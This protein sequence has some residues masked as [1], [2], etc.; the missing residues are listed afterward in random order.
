MEGLIVDNLKS[1]KRG[2]KSPLYYQ[3]IGLDILEVE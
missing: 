2:Q 3:V 1:L